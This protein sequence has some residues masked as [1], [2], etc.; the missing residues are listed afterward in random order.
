MVSHV[1]M[2]DALFMAFEQG[3]ADAVRAVC[4]EDLEARQ[5][6]GPAMSREALIRF[7]L[8]VCRVVPDFHYEAR[9]CAAIDNGFVEEHL[10]CGTLPDG[11]ELRLAACVVADVRDGRIVGMREYVD[12]AAAAGLL[13]AL[14][15]R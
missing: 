2:A 5:N 7:A 12:S 10:V 15:A 8:A 9:R 6:L 13:A 14:S 11:G 4:A 1:A 3:D